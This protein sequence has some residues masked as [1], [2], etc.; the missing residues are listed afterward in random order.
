[1]SAIDAVNVVVD[2]V[3]IRHDTNT[4]LKQ[5]FDTN[6]TKVLVRYIEHQTSSGR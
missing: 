3:S 2:I 4:I 6:N 5:P 1:M